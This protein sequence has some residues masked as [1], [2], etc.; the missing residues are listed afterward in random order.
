MQAR[1]FIIIA[2]VII[3][4]IFAT[5]YV[6]DRFE[7]VAEKKTDKRTNKVKVLKAPII[8]IKNSKYTS[9]VVITGRV[10]AVDRIELFAEVSGVLQPSKPAFKEGY[11]FNKGQ[12]LIAVDSRE[13]SLQIQAQKAKFISNSTKIIPDLRVDYSLE[14]KKW[15]RKKKKLSPL[16]IIP[17]LPTSDS[18]KFSY[19]LSGR[20]VVDAYYDIK[21]AEAKLAKHHI[22][23]PFSGIVKSS[24]IYPGTLVRA[25]QLLGEFISSDSYELET[26]VSFNELKFIESGD[27]VNLY[28]SE[29][30]KPWKGM[31]SRIGNV[32]NETTQTVN[33]YI[34]LIGS[35]LKEGMYLRGEII[36]KTIE[37]VV[38]LP[39]ILLQPGNQIYTVENGKLALKNIEIVKIN[40]NNIVIAG[41]NDGE[42][43]ITKPI[44]KAVIGTLVEIITN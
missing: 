26:A 30:K 35:N 32:I 37:N 18:K 19:F 23:A 21:S 40:Q 44:K 34:K 39:R 9:T 13:M 24:T 28:S 41:L 22:Y 11:K 16:K 42:Q 4:S 2:T 5:A 12:T 3:G 1:Q 14:S 36:G 8:T 17:K 7:A 31:L 25:G 27:M 38:T 10:K 6:R 33:I 20:N 29:V 15:E 43:I